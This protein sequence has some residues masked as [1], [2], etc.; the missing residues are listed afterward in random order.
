MSQHEI[1]GIVH[2]LLSLTR[3]QTMFTCTIWL[4]QVYSRLRERS[5]RRLNIASLHGS[6]EEQLI[7]QLVLEAGRPRRRK[8]ENSRSS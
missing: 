5:R 7:A 8:C 2:A 6:T 4:G 1:A 3:G